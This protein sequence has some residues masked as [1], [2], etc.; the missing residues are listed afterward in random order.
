M[1]LYAFPLGDDGLLSGERRTLVDFGKENGCDGITVDAA[2]NIYVS[3][4]SLAKPGVLVVDPRGKEL[5]F[6]PTGPTNQSG[7]FDDWRGI[8][9]N[10]EFGVGDDRH[11]LYVTHRSRLYS[12]PRSKQQGHRRW[13]KP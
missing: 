4:R 6:L 12:Y 7:S 10:V 1:R 9:S 13:S 3:C 11:T 2:G 8:P 5:A